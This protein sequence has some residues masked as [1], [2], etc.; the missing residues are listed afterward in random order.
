MRIV[1]GELRGRT[2]VTPRSTAIRPT[3]DR[4][5]EAIFNIIAHR[6]TGG[7]EGARVLDLFAGTGALGI[8][9]LSRGAAMCLFIE[10]AA[11][12]RGLI[13]D[14]VETFGLTGRSKI[15][16]RDATSLGEVGTMQPFDLVFA[17]PPYGKA[18]G[19]RALESAVAGGWL[20]PGAMIV[21]EEASDAPF[22]PPGGFSVADERQYGDT[23]V[24][25]LDLA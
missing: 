13:R 6:R 20:S 12:A 4:T 1:G 11:E 23:V 5:R 14:N 19:E 25:F 16:R 9:A 7:L 2:L 10:E 21:L 3:S 24:R 22:A 15:F 17:D 8:E 18:L